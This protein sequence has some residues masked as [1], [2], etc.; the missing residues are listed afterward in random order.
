MREKTRTI[1]IV[2]PES[3][4]RKWKIA[5]AEI[6]GGGRDAIEY[7]IDFYRQNKGRRIV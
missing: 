7:L 6:G 4:F 2:V 3:L 1:K 5:V